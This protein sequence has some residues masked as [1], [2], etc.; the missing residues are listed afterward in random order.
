M[1]GLRA[2]QAEILQNLRNKQLQMQRQQQAARQAML[3]ALRPEEIAA[4]QQMPPV[5]RAAPTS[6]S[7]LPCLTQ[8]DSAQ[9]ASA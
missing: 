3:Q 9:H 5:R 8:A 4:L 1:R 7:W 2:A 6:T